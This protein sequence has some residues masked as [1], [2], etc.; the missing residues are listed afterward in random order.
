MESPSLPIPE[1]SFSLFHGLSQSCSP[2]FSQTWMAKSERVGIHTKK[3]MEEAGGQLV[4]WDTSERGRVAS[5]GC[6]VCRNPSWDR[7][8]YTSV[9]GS[10]WLNGAE[11]RE[12]VGQVCRGGS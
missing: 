8:P 3:G 4:W 6:S 10:T 5:P 9:R 11:E 7:S 1:P 2:F 12:R